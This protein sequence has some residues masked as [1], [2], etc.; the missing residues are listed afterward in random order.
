MVDRKKY[1]IVKKETLS[2][3]DFPRVKFTLKGIE[4]YEDVAY[5]NR[6]K[7]HIILSNF[8]PHNKWIVGDEIKIDNDKT[9]KRDST[10]AFRRRDGVVFR[11]FSVTLDRIRKENSSL[12]G[13]LDIILNEFQEEGSDDEI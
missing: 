6:N 5:K 13:I 9:S 12:G 10:R 2:G 1:E 3:G 7:K 8:H 4:D 11:T